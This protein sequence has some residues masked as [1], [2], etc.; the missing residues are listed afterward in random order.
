MYLKRSKHIFGYEKRILFHFDQMKFC[1]D[2]FAFICN[3]TNVAVHARAN[4]D[5]PKKC[6]WRVTY[7]H[8]DEE[9]SLG[10]IP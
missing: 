1:L 2:V 4:I 5:T 3:Q 8:M 6:T 7:F 9:I 10:E